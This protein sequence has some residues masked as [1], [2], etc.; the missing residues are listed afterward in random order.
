MTDR[1]AATLLAFD[2]GER[3]I[4]VAVGERASLTASPLAIIAAR[5]G[6]PDWEA[7]KRLVTEWSPVALVVGLPVALDGTRHPLA[8]RAKRFARQLHE[9][10]RL[11]VYMNDER[12]TSFEARSRAPDPRGPVDA[13]A[14]QVILEGWLNQTSAPPAPARETSR[15]H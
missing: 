6:R 4:G 10:Y 14:A 3:R 5:N 1:A 9:R 8:A 7:V 12:L 2:F 11:P 15:A 13:I